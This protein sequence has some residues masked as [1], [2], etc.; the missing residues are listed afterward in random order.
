[1]ASICP[2]CD[3]A[4]EPRKRNRTFPFCTP[5]C[6]MVDLGN[7]FGE[8][9]VASRPIDPDGDAEALDAAMREKEED[10]Q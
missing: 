10:V 5:R 8:S 1:M 7:W 2:I 6:K 3:K 4:V 9:Y